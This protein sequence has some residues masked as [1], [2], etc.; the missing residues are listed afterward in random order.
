MCRL[1]L[2]FVAFISDYVN[3][4]FEVRFETTGVPDCAV[5]FYVA[6]LKILQCQTQKDRFRKDSSKKKEI[7]IEVQSAAQI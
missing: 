5:P 7:K 6:G 3:E 2:D 1:V 4:E